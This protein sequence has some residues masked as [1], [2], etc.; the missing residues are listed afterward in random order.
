[1]AKHSGAGMKIVLA[2]D[3]H[4]EDA[5][6]HES[7]SQQLHDTLQE[8][9]A[10]TKEG[11]VSITVTMAQTVVPKLRK[12]LATVKACAGPTFL[13]QKLADIQKVE[14][15]LERAT[16][17]AVDA[18]DMAFDKDQYFLLNRIKD[19]QSNPV[20]TK[21][22]VAAEAGR[23]QSIWCKSAEEDGIAALAGNDF[24]DE[25]VEHSSPPTLKSHGGF[26]IDHIWRGGGIKSH[27]SRFPPR[28]LEHNG[29]RAERRSH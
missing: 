9:E 20:S 14:C 27:R 19:C 21:V 23:L 11:R 1:M 2:V 6:S 18:Q 22:K 7:F 24:V 29:L 16:N 17:L 10:W 8:V 13:Q 28:R 25:W 4:I 3:K 5:A 12:S 26:C 15:F